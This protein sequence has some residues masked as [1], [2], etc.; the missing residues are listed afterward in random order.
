MYFNRLTLREILAVGLQKLPFRWAD[1]IVFVLALFPL[2]AGLL[3]VS[4]S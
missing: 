4:A 1:L 3:M 2:M